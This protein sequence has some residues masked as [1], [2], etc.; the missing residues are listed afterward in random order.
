MS[1][2]T[3]IS[4]RPERRTLT[5]KE[6]KVLDSVKRMCDSVAED[7]TPTEECWTIADQILATCEATPG[8]ELYQIPLCRNSQVAIRFSYPQNDTMFVLTAGISEE[9][10][11][12]FFFELN[13]EWYLGEHRRVLKYGQNCLYRE[14]AFIEEHQN[15]QNTRT[16][17]IKT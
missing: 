7:G 6:R 9:D 12:V 4:H 8:Y 3:G 17:E 1:V 14:E 2:E 13:A 15:K 10:V 11:N 16:K 5:P